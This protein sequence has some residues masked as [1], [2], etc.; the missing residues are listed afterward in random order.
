MKFN[1]KSITSCLLVFLILGAFS[2]VTAYGTG[3]VCVI[4]DLYMELTLPSSAANAVTEPSG[5]T[6]LYAGDS[7]GGTYTL[8]VTK[9]ET[10]YS[11]STF[12]YKYL[13]ADKINNIVNNTAKENNST[14]ATFSEQSN[15]ILIMYFT[16][17]NGSEQAVAET[18]V[19]GMDI[20]ITMAAVSGE[21][22]VSA[23]GEFE[24]MVSS[25]NFTQLLNKPLQVDMGAIFISVFIIIFIVAIILAVLILAYYRKNGNPSVGMLDM[26]VNRRRGKEAAKNYYDELQK[27]GIM[28]DNV[29]QSQGAKNK[30]PVNRPKRQPNEKTNIIV[31]HKGVKTVVGTVDNWKQMSLSNKEWDEKDQNEMPAQNKAEENLDH[32]HV[33]KDGPLLSAPKT[34]INGTQI[35]NNESSVELSRNNND[36]VDEYEYEYDTTQK[37]KPLVINEEKPSK[38]KGGNPLPKKYAKM[39]FGKHEGEEKAADED[40]YSGFAAETAKS[41]KEKLIDHKA[42][43]K[44]AVQQAKP[45]EELKADKAQ[46]DKKPSKPIKQRTT[47]RRPTPQKVKNDNVVSSFETDSYW[48]K[49]K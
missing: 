39:F 29:H 9:T 42:N 27:Q 47:P 8:T 34:E 4:P 19:N 20:K 31:E 11:K 35:T 33:E 45:K 21:L 7:A 22:T 16:T 36:D 12:N 44:P 46:Q 48:D 3:S 5:N 30:K 40:V 17:V 41:G 25:V 15:D 38:E 24:D 1:I 26:P 32:C 28:D 43:E 18:I 14:A 37:S 23:K 49:Y 6:Y 10:E 2:A 13:T